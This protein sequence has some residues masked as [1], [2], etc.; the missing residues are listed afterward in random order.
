MIPKIT[1]DVILEVARETDV[2][3][4]AA[5]MCVYEEFRFVAEMLRASKLQEPD[6]FNSVR[7]PYFGTFHQHER[8]IEIINQKNRDKDEQHNE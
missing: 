2:S 5:R 4:E 1:R 8:K 3:F 7:L 6:T